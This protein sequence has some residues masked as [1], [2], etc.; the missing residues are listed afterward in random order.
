MRYAIV[1]NGIVDNVVE[2]EQ[3]MAENWVRSDDAGIGWLYDGEGFTQ[4]PAPVP[5]VPAPLVVPVTNIQ[6]SG[7]TV[8]QVGNIYWVKAGQAVTITADV[9]LPDGRH[10]VMLDEM[11]DATQRA[12]GVREPATIANGRFT[13]N[14]TFPR[15]GNFLLEADRLSRGFQRIGQNIQLQFPLVEFDVYGGN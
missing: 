13:L 8:E 6:V 11:V 5:E 4:P 12:P 3:S 1:I 2:A 10:M 14:V 15:P 9:S 7:P